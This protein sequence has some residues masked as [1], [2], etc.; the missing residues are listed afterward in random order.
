M[1]KDEPYTAQFAI[2]RKRKVPLIQ[3][4]SMGVS[5]PQPEAGDNGKVLTVK[6]DL[7]LDW[8]T[9][10][11]GGGD[12]LIASL[13]ITNSQLRANTPITLVA[14]PGANK[15]IICA[16]ATIVHNYGGTNVWTAL[17]GAQIGY[18]SPLAGLVTIT[19]PT[20]TA[21]SSQI[22]G[23]PYTMAT[24]LALSSIVDKDLVWRVTVTG[25]GNAANDNTATVFVEYYVIDV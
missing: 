1:N 16:N 4:G 2:I 23:G 8:E 18:G 21:V 6:S 20:F 13:V 22:R 19:A 12:V 24:G 3:A 11:G 14:A 9:P 10:T 17:S 5:L 7:T 25:T 15:V